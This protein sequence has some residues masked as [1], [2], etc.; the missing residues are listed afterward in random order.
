MTI[1][2]EKLI[3]EMFEK[4]ILINEELLKGD[5]DETLLEKLKTE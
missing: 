3:E 1:S 2:R 5:I 4:G